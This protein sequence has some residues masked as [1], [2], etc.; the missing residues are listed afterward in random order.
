[1]ALRLERQAPYLA[2]DDMPKETFVS[3]VRGIAAPRINP[4]IQQVMLHSGRLSPLGS[5]S[6]GAVV[7]RTFAGVTALPSI[8]GGQH[9]IHNRDIATL[10]EA[11]SAALGQGDLSGGDEVLYGRAGL[12]LAL[13]N[14]RTL[15]LE[16]D[17]SER[18]PLLPLCEEIPK[19]I[20]VIIKAGKQ[21]TRDYEDMHDSKDALP[22]MWPWHEKYYA[23]A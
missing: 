20:D 22:L 11:V 18:E 5:S 9:R 16:L 1:M 7:V 13:L 23:G 14:I 2:T 12:L 17:K 8:D 10:Q 21:G 3:K 15:A 19:L 4:H 6:L